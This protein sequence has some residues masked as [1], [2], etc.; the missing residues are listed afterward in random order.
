VLIG[1]T[2]DGDKATCRRFVLCLSTDPVDHL[3]GKKGIL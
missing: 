3:L 1:T 2:F